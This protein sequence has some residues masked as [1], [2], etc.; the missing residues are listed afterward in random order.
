M[1]RQVKVARVTP[2]DRAD[3]ERLWQAWQ[4]HMAGNVPRPV[5]DRTWDLMIRP[6]SGLCALLARAPDGEAL[7]FAN[8]S[9]TPFAWTGGPILFL[10]DLYVAEAARGFGTG[11]A[12][13]KGVYN[14]AD[15][16]GAVQVFWMV[17]EDDPR[18]QGFYARH[19]IRTPY[20]RYMRKDWPW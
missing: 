3:W 7:G 9:A 20:L 1:A 11:E 12:L 5:T 6:E 17:D 8:V 16:L 18:L 19:G 10:Q 2:A 14:L 13:L 4:D 15:E